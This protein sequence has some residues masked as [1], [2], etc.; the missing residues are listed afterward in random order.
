M[1]IHGQVKITTTHTATDLWSG[2]SPYEPMAEPT[3]CI[4]KSSHDSDSIEGSGGRVVRVSGL[5]DWDQP[6]VS[7]LVELTGIRPVSTVGEYVAINHVQVVAYGDGRQNIGTINITSLADGRQVAA[8]TPST[9]IDTDA[10]YAIP[11]GQTLTISN[12]TAQVR[13]STP[14]YQADVAIMVYRNAGQSSA[15]W[16]VLTWANGPTPM[17]VT[18]PAV[19][20]ASCSYV[21]QHYATV[22]VTIDGE[23]SNASTS[24]GA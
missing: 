6:E 24:Q 3:A 19:I 11:A 15:G 17:A 4:I 14:A 1:R 12:A 2:R 10:V 22:A 9:G 18:G 23:I 21:N 13:A 16:Q 7:E 8:V 5:P 20:K